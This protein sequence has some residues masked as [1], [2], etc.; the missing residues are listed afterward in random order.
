[1]KDL[2]SP[3]PKAEEEEKTSKKKINLASI[4]PPAK[5]YLLL[6]LQVFFQGEGRN[7]SKNGTLNEDLEAHPPTIFPYIKKRNKMKEEKRT[8]SIW[9]RRVI[10]HKTMHVTKKSGVYVILQLVSCGKGSV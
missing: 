8:R 5:K 3:L 4:V 7:V 9:T 6:P 10:C 2:Q 1:M